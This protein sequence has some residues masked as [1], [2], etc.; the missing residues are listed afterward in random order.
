MFEF[1]STIR[2]RNKEVVRA[3]CA[4][5]GVDPGSLTRVL[6]FNDNVRQLT[7]LAKDLG[8]SVDRTNVELAMDHGHIGCADQLFALERH[9]AAGELGEGD[10]IALTS[11]SS[12]M[13]WVCTL[14]EV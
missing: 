9:L 7:E 10:V 6:H 4:R 3:A 12:G 1:V 11:T 2:S 13:H 14:L 8:M 5:A